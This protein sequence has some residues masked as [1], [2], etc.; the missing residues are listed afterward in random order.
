MSKHTQHT[1]GKTA[2]PS[3]RLPSTGAACGRSKP[4]ASSPALSF[5][6]LLAPMTGA[7]LWGYTDRGVLEF[8]VGGGRMDRYAS[9]EISEASSW[10]PEHWGDSS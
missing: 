1:L 10:S 6:L 9:S 5:T 4:T 3:T 8:M 2:V 7:D